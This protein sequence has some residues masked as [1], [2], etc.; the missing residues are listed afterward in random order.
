MDKFPEVFRRFEEFVDTDSIESFKELHAE[1]SS[2]FGR[3]WIDSPKQN[4]ALLVEWN[5][6][7]AKRLSKLKGREREKIYTSFLGKGQQFSPKYG[8]FQ[9][10]FVQKPRATAYTIRIE[11]YMT[12]HPYAT[13][14]EAR[15]HRKR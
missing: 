14:A 11:Q 15:G 10:W 6:I 9:A 12:K 8:N 2:Y 4:A 13:L 3:K 1:I 7:V 5:G